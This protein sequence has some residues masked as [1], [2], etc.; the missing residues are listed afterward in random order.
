MSPPAVSVTREHSPNCKKRLNWPA[1]SF[2]EVDCCCSFF[3]DSPVRAKIAE[4]RVNFVDVRQPA[5]MERVLQ[6]RIFEILAI[7]DMDVVATA[8]FIKHCLREGTPCTRKPFA[9]SLGPRHP[10]RQ[11][12]SRP[13]AH[14]DQG[15]C[16]CPSSASC[17]EFHFQHFLWVNAAKLLG[18]GDNT[19]FNAACQQ[20][21]RCRDMCMTACHQSASCF[22]MVGS[23][24]GRRQHSTRV[25]AKIFTTAPLVNGAMLASI[26]VASVLVRRRAVAWLF[27]NCE[28]L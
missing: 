10:P 1:C 27:T 14:V 17:F 20:C 21:P 11:C 5:I 4:R 9:T 23:Q 15:L 7:A 28:P 22:E 25:S 6:F 26:F 13:R 24:P 16:R 18:H 12:P 8:S 19:K 3:F 2:V